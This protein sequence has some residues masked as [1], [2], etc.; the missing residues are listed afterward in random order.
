MECPA[1]GRVPRC[2]RCDI[3]LVYHKKEEELVCHYCGAS[4]GSGAGC[5]DCGGRLLLK[6]GA[7]TQAL[8][9]EMKRLLPGV[10]IGRFDSDTVPGRAEREKIV[11]EFSKGR[12]P[13]LI[14]TQLLSHQPGVPKVRLVGIL[15]PETLLGFS[16]YRAGQR[17]FQ[18]VARMS[19]FCQT[20][21][22][23][24]VVIQTPAPVHFSIRAA[25]ARDFRSFYDQEIEFRRVMRYPPLGSLAELT[26][27]GRDVRSLAGRSRELRLLLRKHEP[28][29]EVLGPALAAVS[30]VRDVSRVQ[31]VL[32]AGR[33]ETI[34]RALDEV[35]PRF[36]L[37]KSLAFAYSPFGRS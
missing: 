18:A 12:I 14:G 22:G 37:K 35:L 20:A 19:E 11:R 17:T 10:P 34:D 24:E 7:G 32:R 23:A 15:S 6:R 33:R 5:P 21:A 3:P 27:L 4:A 1:C 8:E 13:V 31:L 25:A 2:R 16:D 29:L 30:K 26:L 9:E 36:R 28:E